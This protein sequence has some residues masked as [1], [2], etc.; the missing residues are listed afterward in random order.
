M[1]LST[2]AYYISTQK[3][4]CIHLWA[5]LDVIVIAIKFV[6]LFPIGRH[7]FNLNFC[8]WTPSTIIVLSSLGLLHFS[9]VRGK[10]S[11]RI[12]SCLHMQAVMS[13][14][15]I[16]L[17][18][19]SVLNIILT[20]MPKQ[21]IGNFTILHVNTGRAHPPP[22]NLISNCKILQRRS[23]VVP[24]S[25]RSVRNQTPTDG[26][27]AVRRQV[28]PPCVW[29]TR[30]SRALRRDGA[31]DTQCDYPAFREFGPSWT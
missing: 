19:R 10:T 12:V 2:W 1:F 31:M 13:N 23:Y 6:S 30:T 22:C 26:F 28:P 11:F 7:A 4:W 29:I 15:P 3:Q 5:V 27:L 21:P 17:N 20:T 8:V 14:L 16:L 24:T 25:I 18:F 9:G